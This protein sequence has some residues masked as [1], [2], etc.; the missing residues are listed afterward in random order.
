MSMVMGATAR[1]QHTWTGDCAVF[2]GKSDPG[3]LFQYVEACQSCQV[4]VRQDFVSFCC[5]PC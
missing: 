2:S 4:A 1:L 3:A 5:C